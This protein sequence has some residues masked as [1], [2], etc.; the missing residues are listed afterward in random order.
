MEIFEG[1]KYILFEEVFL[2]VWQGDH[3]LDILPIIFEE[4]SPKLRAFNHI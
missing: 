3:N 1:G 4:D 2:N